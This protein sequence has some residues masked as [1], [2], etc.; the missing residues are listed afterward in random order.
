LKPRFDKYYSDSAPEKSTVE[1][2]LAKFKRDKMSFE[3]NARS[4]RLKEAVTEKN[5]KKV[6]K[7][8]LK[9]EVVRD[10]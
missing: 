5:I 8:I 7:I 2:W 1:K 6:H 4:R 3:D 10:S 9:S